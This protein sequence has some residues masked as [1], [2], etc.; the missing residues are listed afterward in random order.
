M[1]NYFSIGIESRI[2]LGFDKKRTGSA[3]MND[4]WYGWEGFK[5][6][7][8]IDCKTKTKRIRE[9][10]NYMA[11]LDPITGEETI[12]FATDIETK[13][14]HYISGNPSS[15]VCTNIPQMMGGKMKLWASSKNKELGLMNNQGQ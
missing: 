10:I 9:V 15:F 2:G 3:A 4:A 11:K 6:M 14:E 13:S 8:C 12:I 5:K 7:C 1:C